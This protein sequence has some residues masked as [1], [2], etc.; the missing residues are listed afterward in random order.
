MKILLDTNF[1]YAITDKTDARHD[2]AI[3]LLESM[4]WSQYSQIL[5]NILVVS[6]TYTLLMYRSQGKIH[7]F[8][9]LD[10]LF[11]GKKKF[12][13]ILYPTKSAYQAISKIMQTYA[14]PKKQLS[15]VD[16]SLIYYGKDLAVDHI[17]SFDSHFDGIIMRIS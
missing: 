11:W 15:F 4:D 3:N 17:L 9:E 13:K 2:Q 1:F 16:A 10:E 12:F 5:T 7:L 8:D 6:E 14:S